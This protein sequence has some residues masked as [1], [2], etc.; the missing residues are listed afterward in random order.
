MKKRELFYTVSRNVIGA[1]IM[2]FSVEI[3]QKLKIEP[4]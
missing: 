4:P 1:A 2:E 3:P